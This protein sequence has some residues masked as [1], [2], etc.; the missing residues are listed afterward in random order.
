MT[1][2]IQIHPLDNVLVVC[3]L[4]LPG[5]EEIIQETLHRFR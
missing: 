4:L 2:L 5:D 1:K 3:W